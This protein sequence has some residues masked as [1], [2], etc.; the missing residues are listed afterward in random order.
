M[1]QALAGDF[2]PTIMNRA[3][4]ERLNTAWKDMRLI[5][6]VVPRRWGGVNGS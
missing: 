6:G 4:W 3:C 2:F 1:S 5:Q